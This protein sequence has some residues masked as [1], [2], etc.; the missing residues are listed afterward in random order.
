MENTLRIATSQFPISGNIARNLGY[1]VR[2]MKQAVSE[3]A[4]LIHFPETS[5][6][7]YARVDVPSFADIDWA[8]LRQGEETF[9]SQAKA[10][11]LWVVYGSYRRSDC[12]D[13]LRNCLRVVSDS[14]ETAATYDK[15][16]LHGKGEVRHCEPGT[17]L[18]VFDVNGVKCGL[19]ICFDMCFPQL[20]EDYRA[21]GVKLLF[22]SCYNARNP[23]GSTSLDDLMAA[24]VRTRAA[25]YGMWIS[26]SNSSARHSR[27]A[28]CAARPDGSHNSFRRHSSGIIINDYPGAELGWTY[29]NRTGSVQNG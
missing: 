24:T 3:G 19:L 27:L 29:D 21:R 17:D 20:F 10:Q 15:I 9:A 18:Q 28:A 8:A 6:P 14:G 1:M 13:K 11:N 2:H 4:D 7:G 12:S 23:G 25:D 26:A 16:N 22:L 5:L